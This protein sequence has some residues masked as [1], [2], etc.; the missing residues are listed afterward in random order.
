MER[1]FFV[2]G[3]KT[4]D[5]EKQTPGFFCFFHSRVSGNIG[6]EVAGWI[7]DRNIRE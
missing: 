1:D 5:L 2:I 7:P 6:V 3:I 4:P